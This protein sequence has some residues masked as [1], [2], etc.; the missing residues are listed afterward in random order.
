MIYLYG[1]IWYLIGSIIGS[2]V[3]YKVYPKLTSGDLLF[4][5]TIG[6]VGGLLTVIIGLTHVD[7]KWMN[8]R[9]F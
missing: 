2:Y 7:F 8:K 6:G 4:M 9:I 3:S 1:L 5:F